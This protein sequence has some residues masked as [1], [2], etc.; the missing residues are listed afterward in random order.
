MKIHNFRLYTVIT[1][2]ISLAIYFTNG[3]AAGLS[4]GAWAPELRGGP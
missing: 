3:R 4:A 2:A 1:V